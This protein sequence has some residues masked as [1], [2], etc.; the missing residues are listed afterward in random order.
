MAGL[1]RAMCFRYSAVAPLFSSSV[2]LGLA[3]VQMKTVFDCLKTCGT[4][5]CSLL[6]SPQLRPVSGLLSS[7]SFVFPISVWVSV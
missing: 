3:A 4:L 5:V 6:C 1:N 7:I 2:L